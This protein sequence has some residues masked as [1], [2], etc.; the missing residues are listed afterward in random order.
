MTMPG[1]IRDNGFAEQFAQAVLRANAMA[2]RVL[3][4]VDNSVLLNGC[5]CRPVSSRGTRMGTSS[6]VTRGR[7]G[8]I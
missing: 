5:S 4:S 7:N 2:N 8:G 6:V 3:R 1:T